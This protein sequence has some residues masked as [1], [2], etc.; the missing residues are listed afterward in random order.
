MTAGRALIA[1]GAAGLLALGSSHKPPPED[2]RLV[3]EPDRPASRRPPPRPSAPRAYP[4]CPAPARTILRSQL[5][6]ILA[7]GPGVFLAGTRVEMI[8]W[9]ALPMEARQAWSTLR[10]PGR[11]GTFGGWQIRRFHPGDP[12]LGRAGLEPGDIIVS[13]NDQTL[14]RPDDLVVLWAKLKTAPRLMVRLVHRNRPQLIVVRIAGSPPRQEPAP[15]R[16]APDTD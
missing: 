9:T 13:V 15:R 4:P 14:Q 7:R 6:A 16:R 1:M 8:P 5:D 3:S 10:K 2:A 11:A 12:C